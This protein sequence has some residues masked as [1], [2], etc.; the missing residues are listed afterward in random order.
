VTT[1]KQL[2]EQTRGML[3]QFSTHRPVLATFTGWQT[4]D[5]V[6]T[7]INLAGMSNQARV[8]NAVVELGHELVFVSNHDPSAATTQCPPW[9]RQQQGSPA[10]DDYPV[11]S[12]AVVNP[13]W[14]YCHVA[15]H[16]SNGIA[17]LYPSLFVAKTTTLVTDTLVEK[18]EIPADVKEII[19]VRYEDDVNPARP[20]REVSRWTLQLLNPDGK[21]YLHI[22]QV[23]RSGLNIFVSYRAEPT[24]PALTSDADWSTTG[25]PATAQD[26]P[27]LWATAQLLPTADAAKTQITSVEQSERNRFVQP[28]GANAASKRFQDIYDR[29][30][31][32]EK[33]KLLDLFPPRIHRTLN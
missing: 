13:Q 21:K 26:L 15:Q 17:Q 19:T 25:L 29:R 12:V 23:Y 32:E 28:G 4:T 6:K 3:N 16:V 30:L 11:N 31:A 9:F 1:F 22:E 7:G 18:Y 5:G 14:P 10:N 33:R 8:S 20:Q 27:V 24:M 2:V